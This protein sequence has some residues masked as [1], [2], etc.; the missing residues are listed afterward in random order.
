LSAADI[1]LTMTNYHK[2]HLLQLYPH[3]EEKIN[4][5]HGYVSG[6]AYDVSDPFEQDVEVY[7]QCFDD[8]HELIVRLAEM[9]NS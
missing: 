2:S 1:A 7:K 8:L 5:L 6:E 4:T 9:I 3:Y